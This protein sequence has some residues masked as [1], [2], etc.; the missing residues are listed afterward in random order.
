MWKRPN[1]YHTPYQNSV[2]SSFNILPILV[3]QG[4]VPTGSLDGFSLISFWNLINEADS[5]AIIQPTN[6]ALGLAIRVVIALQVAESQWTP[7][8]QYVID[9]CGSMEVHGESCPCSLG[10]SYTHTL[11][12]VS[13]AP[14][15]HV[16]HG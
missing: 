7:M 6:S 14:L 10:W 8:S 9:A 12:K 3:F 4:Q 11:P 5:M 16:Y 15:Y 1:E 13:C 2:W